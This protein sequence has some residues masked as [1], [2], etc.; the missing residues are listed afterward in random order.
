LQIEIVLGYESLARETLGIVSDLY[1]ESREGDN[2][3]ISLSLPTNRRSLACRVSARKVVQKV[4][5]RERWLTAVRDLDDAVVDLTVPG[6]RQNL[7]LDV[8]LQPSPPLL[9][10]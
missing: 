7:A 9:N 1:Q 3:R 2:P 5:R 8:L 4:R 6:D 10:P